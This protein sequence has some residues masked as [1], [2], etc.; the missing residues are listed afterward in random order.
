MRSPMLRLVRRSSRELRLPA[1]P[2][3]ESA[4]HWRLSPPG[5]SVVLRDGSDN[6]WSF[7]NADRNVSSRFS[8]ADST[9]VHTRGHNLLAEPILRCLAEA[10][11]EQQTHPAMVNMEIADVFE[12]VPQPLRNAAIGDIPI[13]K[14]T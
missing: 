13:A 14:L 10:R 7:Q 8:T 1:P 11:S 3:S 5:S 12:A 4:N 2:G 9:G 6:D